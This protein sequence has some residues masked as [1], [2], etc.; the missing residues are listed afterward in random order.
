MRKKELSKVSKVRCNLMQADV[1]L[2]N[3]DICGDCQSNVKNVGKKYYELITKQMPNGMV[4]ELVEVDYPITPASVKSYAA[5]A[6]YRNDIN[7]ALS[8]TPRG[9]NLGDLTKVQQVLS[10]DM[11]TARNLY[12]NLKKIFENAQTQAESSAAEPAATEV[13]NV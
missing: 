2:R 8:S 5:S 4:Q 1:Y 12:G 7:S 13:K 11:E 3:P 10:S 6:D 9:K